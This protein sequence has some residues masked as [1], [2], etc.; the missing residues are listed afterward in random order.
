MSSNI[1]LVNTLALCLLA[2]DSSLEREV[3]R[4][5]ENHALL[6]IGCG[7]FAKIEIAYPNIG[8]FEAAMSIVN[9]L[10]RV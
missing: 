3:L 2:L 8:L 4:Q 5:K 1:V 10:E 7:F 9:I 6:S